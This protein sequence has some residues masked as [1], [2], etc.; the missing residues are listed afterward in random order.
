METHLLSSESLQR[1]RVAEQPASAVRVVDRTT[2]SLDIVQQQKPIPVKVRASIAKEAK[3]LFDKLSL[4]V[5]LNDRMKRD[6]DGHNQ[7]EEY[8]ERL[9]LFLHSKRNPVHWLPLRRNT[10]TLV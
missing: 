9:H 1:A 2:P 3:Q 4:H 8:D 10:L 5:E 7:D 6:Q